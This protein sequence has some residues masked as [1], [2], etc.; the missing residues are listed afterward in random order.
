MFN[1]CENCVFFKTFHTIKNG[2]LA[3]HQIGDCRKHAPSDK[4][5]PETQSDSGCGD[6][7]ESGSKKYEASRIFDNTGTQYLRLTKDG[8]CCDLKIGD[9]KCYG[10]DEFFC[11]ICNDVH[12]KVSGYLET[13]LG[14]MCVSQKRK[15]RFWN[16][17]I[18]ET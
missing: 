5:Y 15:S 17:F 16:S 6:F 4:G 12:P 1:T 8:I 14:W 7:I 18:K 11:I 10:E 2:K 3:G 13:T 9:P